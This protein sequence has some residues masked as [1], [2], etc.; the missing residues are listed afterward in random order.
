MRK[1]NTS[2]EY[3]FQWHWSHGDKHSSAIESRPE[4]QPR[5]VLKRAEYHIPALD[6]PQ[7]VP[8]EGDEKFAWDSHPTPIPQLQ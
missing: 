1:H 7:C 3:L 8:S 4:E 5:D 6:Y 2:S